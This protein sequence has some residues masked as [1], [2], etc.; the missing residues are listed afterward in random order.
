MQEK[1]AADQTVLALFGTRWCHCCTFQSW[2]FLLEAG[3]S[4][5]PLSCFIG[6]PSKR[7][8]LYFIFDRFFSQPLHLLFSPSPHVRNTSTH[9][10]YIDFHFTVHGAQCCSPFDPGNDS[11][12]PP[13]HKVVFSR[14]ALRYIAGCLCGDPL[15]RQRLASI[16]L[17]K[18]DCLSDDQGVLCCN[19]K[20]SSTRPEAKVPFAKIALGIQFEQLETANGQI[21][22][23][24]G[25]CGKVGRIYEPCAE[26]GEPWLQRFLL[27][28]L[29]S[30]L[31]CSV[32]DR[33][34]QPLSSC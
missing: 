8:A 5:W 21:W 1:E 10:C 13:T 23:V 18:K 15:M 33:L 30:Q 7:H 11:E 6:V 22:T 27:Q 24:S 29:T 17:E 12:P 32:P 3:G 4:L 19:F 26:V 28:S 2:C 9:F 34:L 31:L 14:C 20:V 25:F 16:S